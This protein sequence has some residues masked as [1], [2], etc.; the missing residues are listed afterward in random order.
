MNLVVNALEALP[1][2]D[3]GVTV[4]TAYDAKTR[5]EILEV[6][7]EG[8]GIAREHLARL[9]DPFFTTKQA[10]GGTGLGLAITASLVRAHG[11]RLDFDSELGKGTQAVVS[12]PD[13]EDDAAMLNTAAG[14]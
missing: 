6:R 4:S 12:F 10:T 3:K 9:C 2:R 14:S 13:L 11:A 7:D 5:C 8:I 1:D